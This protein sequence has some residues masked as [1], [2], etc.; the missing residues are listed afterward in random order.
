MAKDKFGLDGGKYRKPSDKLK[1]AA[2]Q[3]SLYDKAMKLGAR[4]GVIEL[5][6]EAYRFHELERVSDKELNSLVRA[7]KK[8]LLDNE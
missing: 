8:S 4:L 7:F 6:K 5:S 2:L 3:L 1:K